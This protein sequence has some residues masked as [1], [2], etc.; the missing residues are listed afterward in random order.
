[1]G[2]NL[3]GRAFSHV[4]LG[5]A[6]D[7]GYWLER[8]VS[9]S[10]FKVVFLVKILANACQLAPRVGATLIAVRLFVST[11]QSLGVLDVL[12]EFSKGHVSLR[13]KEYDLVDNVDAELQ[14][15][16]FTTKVATSRTSFSL[17]SV[18]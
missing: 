17:S 10:P 1:M 8:P 3:T 7:G 2:R 15:Q 13:D 12:L 6:Q 16:I 4:L 14:P 5:L 11:A 18:I 9:W